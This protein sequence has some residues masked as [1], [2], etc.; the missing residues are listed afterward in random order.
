VQGLLLWVK[1]KDRWLL[2]RNQPVG[3]IRTERVWESTRSTAA[4]LACEFSCLCCAQPHRILLDP[5][6]V[7]LICD[8][9]FSA[10]PR[11][12]CRYTQSVMHAI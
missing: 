2:R 4:K 1:R 12:L 9:A 10:S 7:P 5:S 6:I 8:S 3:E 11:V